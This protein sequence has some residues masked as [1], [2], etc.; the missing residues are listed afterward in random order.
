[1]ATEAIPAPGR[2]GDLLSRAGRRKGDVGLV[3]YALVA[4]AFLYLPIIVIVA[5]SFNESK[6]VAVWGGFS[7]KWYGE[8][9]RNA[10]V[11]EAL[12]NSLIVGA[13]TT[14]GATAIGSLMALAL[15]RHRFR[16]RDLITALLLASMLVP[17][18]VMG[19]SMLMFY[20]RGQVI[21]GIQTIV[22][23][24]IAFSIPFA[25]LIVKARLAGMDR[26]LEEAGRDL[27]GDAFTVWRTVTLPI[28]A[29]GILAAALLAFT[30]SFDDFVI[31]FFVAGPG[32]TTLPIRI[33]SMVKV[34][35]TPAINALST[36]VVG[37]SLLLMLGG[38]LRLRSTR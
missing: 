14:V 6:Q 12:K 33:F 34:G 32:T 20:V 21:L 5:Y 23:S 11:I 31:T 9:L 15:D 35:I 25:A 26:T 30:L 22:I 16:G 38:A 8:I 2:I 19:L 17:E 27:G 10:A 18:I 13:L 28:M 3:A 37:I 36:L 7:F 4:Y 24:H 29:P 1:M